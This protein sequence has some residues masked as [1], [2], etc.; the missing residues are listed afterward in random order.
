MLNKYF[1]LG[2]K[3]NMSKVIRMTRKVQNKW[4]FS[5]KR[6]WQKKIII[7]IIIDY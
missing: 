2:K 5:K 7:I 3:A 6:A 1:L 4:L